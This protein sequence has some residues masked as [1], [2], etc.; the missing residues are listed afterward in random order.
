MTIKI[1][2]IE[3]AA[4]NKYVEARRELRRYEKS[5]RPSEE[6]IANK[7]TVV[8]HWKAKAFPDVGYLCLQ[9]ELI[10]VNG[11]AQRHTYTDAG[12]IIDRLEGVELDLRKRGVTLANIVGTTV[13]LLS[14]VP[15]AKSYARR[16]RTAIASLI[17]AERRSTGWFVTKVSKIER[18]TGPGADEKIVP[19][20]SAKAREDIIKTALDGLIVS[21]DRV[22]TA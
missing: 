11:R 21:A 15:T 18:Y 2:I 7:K 12:T 1:K 4:F 16:S 5:F 19:T 3:K 20:I 10:R 22:E 13:T 14:E 6:A 17:L 8:A 9:V